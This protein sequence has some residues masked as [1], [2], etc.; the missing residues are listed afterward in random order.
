LSGV[1]LLLASSVWGGLAGGAVANLGAGDWVA[2]I[3][4]F[5]CLAMAGQGLL[6]VSAL[7]FGLNLYWAIGCPLLTCCPKAMEKDDSANQKTEGKKS[8]ENKLSEEEA[9][10]KA[11][12]LTFVTFVV[13]A[14]LVIAFAGVVFSLIL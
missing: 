2:A 3:K 12:K 8:V 14:I 6:F 1:T 9:G 5:N 11:S 13:T 10:L 4:P 7:L